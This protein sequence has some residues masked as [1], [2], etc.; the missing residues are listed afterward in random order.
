MSHWTILATPATSILGF[1][2]ID[3][4]SAGAQTRWAHL[5]GPSKVVGGTCRSK[6]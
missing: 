2:D 4:A 3:T 6:V 5:K 1:R